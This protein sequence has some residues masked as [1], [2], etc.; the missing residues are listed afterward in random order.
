MLICILKS[1]QLKNWTLPI[2]FKRLRWHL[3][4]W[5][6]VITYQVIYVGRISNDYVGIIK[7][8]LPTLPFDMFATYFAMYFL[9]PRFLLKKKYIL[10]F[11][12]LILFSGVIIFTELVIGYYIQKPLLAPEMQIT[13]KSYIIDLFISTLFQI[14]SFTVLAVSIKLIKLWFNY[15]QEKAQL[16]NQSLS[17]ELA[18]LRSQ[19]NPHFLFN[20]LNN[21]DS[22]VRINPDKASNSIIKLS[23]IMRYM[24]YDSNADF[25]PLE[26]EIEYIQSFVSLQQLR[27]KDPEFTSF[28]VEGESKGKR[29]PP[30]LIIPFVENAYKHG[31]KNV[32]APGIK[33][34]IEIQQK[35]Y[36]FSIT[37]AYNVNEKVE[38]D[39]F[40]GYGLT[41]IRRRLDLLYK[42]N[43][44]LNIDTKNGIYHV[45]LT[46]RIL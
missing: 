20:T 45:I 18:L 32:K 40:S 29:I 19:I 9:V 13:L 2:E 7:A 25:V 43:Y 22:L 1:T 28:V 42:D 14:Y 37:N 11:I 16:K 36:T 34:H 35:L 23:E 26:K 8:M 33:I 12:T 3:L 44:Y 27:F 39:P 6:V 38:K 21:I 31:K 5:V 46:I 4:F 41:N 17:S 10:F 24:L 15:Q 30:M